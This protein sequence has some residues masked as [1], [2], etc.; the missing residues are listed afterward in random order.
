M[1]R[2][3]IYGI[4]LLPHYIVYLKSKHINLINEDVASFLCI[5]QRSISY[6]D[7]SAAMR[8][9]YF[10]SVFYN[11]IGSVYRFLSWYLPSDKTFII[12]TK[13]IMGGGKTFAPFCY[14][15]SCKK[16]RKEF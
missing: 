14:N 4:L 15:N 7:F 12:D 2:R 13:S 1:L 6:K 9:M 8:N 16:Y 3:I 5:C 10:R 11:R